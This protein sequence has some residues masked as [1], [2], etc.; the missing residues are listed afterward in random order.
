MNYSK[1]LGKMVQRFREQASLSQADLAK[2]LPFTAS[3]ISRLESSELSLDIDET[4]KIAEA[5]GTEDSKAFADY[6]HW[7]WCVL[8]AP[9]FDHPNLKILWKAE[10][11]L[12]RLDKLKDDPEIKN[13][14]IKQIDMCRN[15]LLRAAKYLQCTEH[16][17]AFM[18]SPGV[19][20]TTA[21]CAITE[22]LRDRKE[23]DLN[24]QIVLQTGSGRT[25]ICEVHVRRGGEYSISIEPC[26]YEELRYH[27]ADFCEYLLNKTQKRV[28][29]EP[30]EGSG[31]SAEME[32]TLRNMTALTIKK[33]KQQ[34][35][36]YFREDPANNLVEQY[37]N[38]EE[39]LVELLAR[40]NSPHRRRT[41]ITYAPL[42]SI[43]PMKWISKTFAQINF[44]RHPEFSLP[45]RIEVSIPNSVLGSD[46]INIRLID[47]RG[48]DEPSAPRRDLQSYLDDERAIVVLCSRFEDAPSA[49]VQALIERAKEGGLHKAIRRQGIL[50]VLPKE[51]EEQAVL[52]DITGEPVNDAYEGREIR[53]EQVQTT[54][55]ANLGVSDMC[56]DFMNVR[57]DSDCKSV[58][59]SI[60]SAIYRLRMDVTEQ[61]T[62]L[63]DTADELIKNKA[64]EQVR[65]VFEHATKPIQTWLENNQQ[66]TGEIHRVYEALLE[67]MD[68]LRYAAS[69]RASI[70]RRGN[71]H[72]FDYWHGLGF[73]ARRNAVSISQTQVT[74]LKGI[75]KNA[76]NDDDLEQAH[77]FLRQ[78]LAQVEDAIASLFIDIQQVGETAFA[79]P[80]RGDH[81][82]WNKCQQYWGMGRGY[83]SDIRSETNTW[84]SA[85]ARNAR[86]EFLKAELQKRWIKMI[87]SLAQHVQST[88]TSTQIN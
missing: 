15:Q 22:E 54:T 29:T 62:V 40:F 57:T 50:L 25:T 44:G 60:L 41:S 79:E 28:G 20:K 24:R 67:E 61:I 58:R 38:K 11:A 16:S 84:F 47:T 77:G 33:S 36:K 74:E 35:G 1:T 18:G 72:N 82:Y 59:D 76:L 81:D 68:S 8:E 32:R 12:Q 71:W 73:G 70:N 75:I 87:E 46:T 86:H 31:I 37:P 39:L 14:F 52:S 7:N 21:I 83:I 3:R 80:L 6:L 55:L 85:E 69:L 56:I 43:S 13:V 66:T 10:Q 78:F 88:P 4:V 5:I 49:A 48:I 63:V 64:D 17:I 23:E 42:S 51:G 26:S 45:K 27:V 2:R 65:I 34:D 30:K 53:Q 9:T 19:G